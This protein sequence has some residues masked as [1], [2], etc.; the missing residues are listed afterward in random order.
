MF[1][2]DFGSKDDY[3]G[4]GYAFAIVAPRIIS[5][6]AV[7]DTQRKGESMEMIWGPPLMIGHI[8]R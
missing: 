2:G 4:C 1:V 6:Q 8:Q 7:F 5:L 3:E